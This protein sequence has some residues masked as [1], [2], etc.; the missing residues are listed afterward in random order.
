[1]V[2]MTSKLTLEIVLQINEHIQLIA[3]QHADIEY[4]GSEYY[5]VKVRILE[6]M[7]ESAPNFNILDTASYYLKNII[8]L[9][10]FPD[11]NH[12]TALISVQFF[13]LKNGIDDFDYT[14]DEAF[15]FQKECYKNRFKVY[16]TY[17]EM[18]YYILEESDNKFDNGVFMLCWNFIKLHS[19]K[20]SKFY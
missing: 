15:T 3:S 4:E 14:S 13:L 7:I 20:L 18:G 12:R 5:P 2:E 17:E 6:R 1:M 10:A 8:L 11:A 16:R 9:Q 19:K